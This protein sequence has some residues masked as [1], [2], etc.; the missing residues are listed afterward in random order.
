MSLLEANAVTT[1]FVTGNGLVRAVQ[2]VDLSL[3]RGRVLGVVGESGSGKSALVRSI[4]GLYRLDRAAICSGSITFD[5]V[6]LDQLSESSLRRMWGRRIAIVFQNPLSSLNPVVTI[7]RQI[8]ESLRRHTGLSKVLA[9]SRACELLQSV[10]MPDP[11]RRMGEYPHQLSGGM[12][13]RVA[14]AIALSSEPELLIADEPTTALDVTVQAQVLRLLRQLQESRAMAMILVSHDFGVV[15]SIADEVAVMYAGRIVEHSAV[16]Q[17]I[18]KPMH[19]YTDALLRSMPRVDQPVGTRLAAIG[20]RPPNLLALPPG[21]AFE[22]RCERSSELCA[23]KRP[24][25]LEE[26]PGR[27]CACWNPLA[28]AP[29]RSSER[30]DRS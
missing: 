4:M 6:S 10:D 20:G 18:E 30:P 17:A 27:L 16:R 25:L 9:T 12:R 19:P 5:G 8:T 15:A 7:G 26:P 1:S 21:C 24:E 29:A 22:P 28:D 11:E 2:E 23:G 3:D 13:Q 14:I